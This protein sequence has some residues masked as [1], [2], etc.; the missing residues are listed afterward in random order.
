[1]TSGSER[2]VVLLGY[3]L[4]HSLSPTLHNASFRAQ[5]LPFVYR[6][7]PVEKDNLADALYDLK[8]AGF[9]GANVT[10]PHKRS[11]VPFLD[12]SSEIVAA[13]GAANTLVWR[14]DFGSGELFGD[15]TDV[16]GFLATLGNAADADAPC[17]ILGSGG[18]ARAVA[19][20]M[21]TASSAPIVTVAGR[22]LDRVESIVGALSDYDSDSRLRGISISAARPSIREAGLIVNAT[23]AGMH[24]NTEVTPWPH[25]EDFRSGQLAYD[26]VYNPAETRFMLDAKEQ[27][28]ETMCGLEMLVQQAALSYYQWTGKT[29][30][31]AAARAALKS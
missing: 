20:A 30:D 14:P 21:I 8:T 16:G 5:D 26:L 2:L 28:A 22:N 10:V 23:P 12:R 7:H 9:A 3:P 17:V 19:F 18:A 4:G 29:M 13:T 15:N 27:G 1:V 25:S 24:P 6:T 31:I 11:I